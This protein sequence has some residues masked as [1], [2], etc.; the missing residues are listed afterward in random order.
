MPFRQNNDIFHLSELTEESIFIFQIRFMQ[1]T[2]RFYS[3][4]RTNILPF[5]KERN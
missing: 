3:Q 4:K 2:K 5:G 1:N